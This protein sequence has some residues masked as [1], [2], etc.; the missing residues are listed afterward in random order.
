MH[1]EGR[2]GSGIPNFVYRSAIGGASVVGVTFAAFL[3]HVNESSAGFLYLLLVVIVALRLG[4]GPATVTSLLAVNCLN[5]FF[6]QPILNFRIADPA[7]WVALSTFEFT[8]LIV[9][10]LSAQVQTQA[11]IA[12]QQSSDRQKLYQLSRGALLMDPARPVESQILGLIQSTLHTES[13][14]LFDEADSRTYGIGENAAELESAAKDAYVLNRDENDGEEGKWS[15]VLTLAGRAIG[16][17]ALRSPGLNSE[18]VDAVASV[19]AIA[20]ERSQSLDRAARAETARHSEQL[21]SAVLDSLAHAFKTP[22]TTVL[23]A[24][25]GLLETGSLQGA[26]LEL[27]TLIDQESERLNN[28]ATQLLR[29]ARLDQARMRPLESC[30]VLELVKQV[31]QDLSW[32]LTGRP[33]SIAI[34]KTLA[35]VRG[36]RELISMGITQLVDN[37]AKYSTPGTVITISG[38]T[39]GKA[40]VVT[41]HNH[42]PVIQPE[43]REKIFERFYRGK[44][45]EHLAAGTGIGLSVTKR[46]AE[47]H[48]GRAWVESEEG[49]GTTFYLSLSSDD[50]RATAPARAVEERV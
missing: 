19:A 4:F 25:S 8:A 46:A 27:V 48:G 45:S 3:L 28:L 1:D 30:D 7:D 34:P 23:A 10:R 38:E 14:A 31:V 47:A 36:D 41:V 42:G 18:V 37:A 16:A 32:E 22:L 12:R 5:Y 39:R 15:R 21:R 29:T 24:S 50:W 44:G 20:I 49:R 13:A 43:E 9:S 35:K 33:V 26:E 17:I 40:N 2:R 6:V 11:R